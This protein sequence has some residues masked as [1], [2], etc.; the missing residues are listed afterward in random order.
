MD[1]FFVLGMP[2]VNFEGYFIDVVGLILL[3]DY[4]A[5]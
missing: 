5:D 2:V 1:Y 3:T 4:Y